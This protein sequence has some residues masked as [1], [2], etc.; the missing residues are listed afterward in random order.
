MKI[1]TRIF[2]VRL[3]ARLG[4]FVS[5]IVVGLRL[6]GTRSGHVT[7]VENGWGRGAPLENSD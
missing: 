1:L 7:R 6:L 3:G 2:G 5:G 4:A